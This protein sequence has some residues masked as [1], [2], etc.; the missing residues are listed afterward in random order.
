M[1][2]EAGSAA[3]DPS[4][5]GAYR[6]APMRSLIVGPYPTRRPP[7]DRSSAN[8]R[9]SAAVE[10]RS[11]SARLAE[12]T[13]LAAALSLDVV[14]ALIVSVNEI[15]PATYMGKGKVEELNAAIK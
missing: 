1:K 4:D 10:A 12:A 14:D 3:G 7:S 6:A 9:P 2:K 8:G 5:G 13:S 11:P 15:R